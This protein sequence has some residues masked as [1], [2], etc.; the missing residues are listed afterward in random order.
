MVILATLKEFRNKIKANND[1]MD[2]D[3]DSPLA[4]VELAEN[5]VFADFAPAK[6]AL[7]A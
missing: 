3:N 7:V 2:L 1:V 5:V 4:E 6:L